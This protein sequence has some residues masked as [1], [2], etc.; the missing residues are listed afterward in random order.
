MLLAHPNVKPI[1]LGPRIL[2]GETATLA[3][4]SLWMGIAGDWAVTGK[5]GIRMVHD[6]S[7]QTAFSCLLKL[8]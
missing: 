7:G 5:V 2:R 8:I 1:T 4:V 6:F 3:A